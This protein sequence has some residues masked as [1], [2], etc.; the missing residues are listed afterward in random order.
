MNSR[1]EVI[2]SQRKWA[3]SLGYKPDPRGYLEMVSQNLRAPLS[4]NAAAAAAGVLVPFLSSRLG[5]GAEAFA[6]DRRG[7]RRGLEVHGDDPAVLPTARRGDYVVGRVRRGRAAG[8][9][10]V[11]SG[12]FFHRF[13]HTS[14]FGEVRNQVK[15]CS[16]IYFGAVAQL[17]EHLL[18]KQGVAGSIPVRSIYSKVTTQ[19][20]HT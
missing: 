12:P 10:G 1:A 4:S 8:E 6:S 18:C 13:L 16:S 20:A 15:F 14:H 3:E 19:P 5:D 17:G 2:A 11:R 7:C 9:E